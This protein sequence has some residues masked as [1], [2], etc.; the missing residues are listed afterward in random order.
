MDKSYEYFVKY[1]RKFKY[2]HWLGVDKDDFILELLYDYPTYWKHVLK[3]I[4]IYHGFIVTHLR[5][6]E[7]KET[8]TLQKN[9]KSIKIKCKIDPCNSYTIDQLEDVINTYIVDI[10][11]IEDI[12]DISVGNSNYEYIGLIVQ[13][14]LWT[15]FEKIFNFM[16]QRTCDLKYLC[17]KFIKEN[18]KLY[19]ESELKNMNRDIRKELNHYRILE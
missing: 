1:I 16:I 12:V 4:F 13:E 3:Y 15:N 19:K 14:T 2:C 11:H 8:F 6:N 5:I 17:I 10:Y 18:N 7:T 9:N